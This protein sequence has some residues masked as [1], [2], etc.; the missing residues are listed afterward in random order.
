MLFEFLFYS[1]RFT[2]PP[3]EGRFYAARAQAIAWPR[4][5]GRLDSVVDFTRAELP[6]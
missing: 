2:D 6:R 4:K 5:R 1:G 3:V